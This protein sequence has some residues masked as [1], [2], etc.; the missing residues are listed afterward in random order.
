MHVRHRSA[1]VLAL[2]LVVAACSAATASPSP[3]IQNPSPGP[4]EWTLRTPFPLPSGAVAVSLPTLPPEAP[5]ASGE[6]WAC[7]AMML[8][9]VTVV[10]DKSAHTVSFGLS[11]GWP[12]GFSARE[13]AGR[14]EIVDPSW[15]AA[16]ATSAPSMGPSIRRPAESREIRI[17]D[18]R[19]SLVCPV[20]NPD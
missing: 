4:V 15:A 1:A 9:P 19:V 17:P 7:P 16:P 10:W 6:A 8:S 13:V 3:T 2:A 11:L 12:R 5:L 20:C 18:D 14:L